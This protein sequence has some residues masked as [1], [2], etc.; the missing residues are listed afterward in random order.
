MSPISRS[1]EKFKGYVSGNY[2]DGD[3]DG[4]LSGK[5]IERSS[6]SYGGMAIQDSKYPY[7]APVK[8][9][10]VAQVL[11]HVQNH[12]GASLARDAVDKR[13]V[14]E[15][16]SW[17]K[18]GELISDETATPMNGPGTISGGEKR[19]DSDGDGI[20]DEVEEKMGGDKGK[21]DSMDDKDGNGYV[22]VEDWANSL[23]PEG[24]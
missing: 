19:V 11:E 17:G 10:R 18:S 21:A 5:E 16:M 9:L 3:K 1:N 2:Y 23:V 13:L 20:P 24:Y 4:V 8:L 15:L 12:A 22:N 7:P 14:E 6:T